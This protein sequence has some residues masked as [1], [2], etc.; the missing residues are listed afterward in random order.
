MRHRLVQL[1][2]SI[3]SK[4][5][6]HAQGRDEIRR[7]LPKAGAA[8][9]P[10]IFDE[11][12]IRELPYVGLGK[13][14]NAGKHSKPPPIFV[15]ARFR[16]GSTLLW[17]LFRESPGVTAY[18]EPFNERRWFSASGR[19]GGVDPTHRG[20][21][22]YWL[23]YKGLSELSEY[24]DPAWTDT[25]LYMDGTSQDAN[26]ARF[27]RTLIARTDNTA[28]LQFNR[29]DFRL[30]WLRQNFPTG[31]IIHLYRHPR[32]QWVSSLYGDFSLPKEATLAQFTA[33]DKFYLLKWIRDLSWQFPI[34]DALSEHHPYAAFYALWRL[35]Y[36]YGRHFSDMSV[37]YEDLVDRPDQEFA[38]VADV[39][40]LGEMPRN[41]ASDRVDGKDL[42]K[43]ERYA[44]ESWYRAIESEVGALLHPTLVRRD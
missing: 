24:Y 44:D 40:N 22:D 3:F 36:V 9:R 7:A 17:R 1:V 39:C 6:H 38:K 12:V 13:I 11:E 28:A 23:E 25:N 29:V 8:P 35:S 30:E 43:A 21:S 31:R 4:L 41:F 5:L 19:A 33:A 26:M 2:L 32:E 16:T 10:P 18:Y 34:L 37:G 15:T 42:S 20:V 27:I 14:Y